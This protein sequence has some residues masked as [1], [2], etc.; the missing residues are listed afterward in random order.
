MPHYKTQLREGQVRLLPCLAAYTDTCSEGRHERDGCACYQ[1]SR[2]LSL[3]RLDH[4]LTAGVVRRGGPASTTAP[5]AGL[6]PV[7]HE[8]WCWIL[9]A[10]VVSPLRGRCPRTTTRN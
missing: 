1:V 5:P 6:D 8:R 10:L 3:T 7:A 2:T 9:V 4:L